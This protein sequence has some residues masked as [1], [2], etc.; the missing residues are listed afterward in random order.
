MKLAKPGIRFGLFRQ[1]AS[2]QLC[3]LPLLKSLQLLQQTGAKTEQI[4]LAKELTNWVQTGR[5]LAEGMKIT[6]KFKKIE[7]LQ[8]EMAE[9]AGQL[10]DCL[11][12][13]AADLQHQISL[14]AK[15]RAALA[16]PCFVLF[17]ASLMLTGL[18]IWVIPTFSSMY[19]SF[20]KELPWLTRQVLN[21]SQILATQSWKLIASPVLT[22][23]F[24]KWQL[25]RSA[26][27]RY[28]WSRLKIRCPLFGQ[29]LKTHCQ[30]RWS[31]NLAGLLAC[32]VPM[33]QALAWSV[34]SIDEPVYIE[35]LQRAYVGILAG[36][37][38]SVSLNQQKLF[39][40][41]LIE[42]TKIGEESGEID[43]MLLQAGE[44]MEI[45]WQSQMQAI[46]SL[47]EPFLLVVTGLVVGIVVLA[48]YLPLL[49]MG[50]LG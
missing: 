25:K 4:D 43:T 26:I 34:E 8:I 24:F 32:G 7:V 2:M 1:L 33:A 15:W 27:G 40:P 44:L 22:V 50:G 48:L 49:E 36:K 39:S 28:R 21:T 13:L 6:N 29:V 12:Q 35:A 18:M 9:H 10:S 30:I 20:H 45:N 19:A 41:V 3:G 11:T 17:T 38:L 46:A 42:W 47:V 14:Q 23:I 31:K 5:P 37:A 16:Y